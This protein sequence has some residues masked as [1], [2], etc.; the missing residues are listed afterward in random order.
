MSDG[1]A[2]LGWCLRRRGRTLAVAAALGGAAQVLLVA[3]PWAVQRALDRGVTPGATAP[4]LAWSGA[5]VGLG[6]AVVAARTVGQR[7][8]YLA[9]AEVVRA[10]RER[11]TARVLELDRAGLAGL[12]PGDAASRH[13]RDADQLW[14]WIGG[15]VDTVQLLVATAATVVAIALLDPLLALAGLAAVPPMLLLAR[16]F[17][18]RYEAASGRL[19][20][21]HAERT[22][23]VEALV[24][25]A[26]TVRGTGGEAELLARHAERSARV[27]AATRA[28]A[29]VAAPWSALVGLVPLLAAVAGLVIGGHALV[30]G[31]LT[32]GGLVAFAA[33]TTMLA[34]QVDELVAQQAVR[35]A[36]VASADRLA[37]VLGR[38]PRPAGSV[39][40]PGRGRLRA[41]GVVVRH[42]E[43]EVVRLPR[44]EIGPGE[45]V[46]LRGTTGSGK[47][48]LL[49]VLAGL[50]RPAAGTVSF[51]GVDLAAADPETVCARIGYVPQRPVLV[52]GTVAEN[53]LL[54]ASEPDDRV[55]AAVALD[56]LPAPGTRVGAGA[57]GLSGGQ[58]QRLAVARALLA[59]PAVLLLDDVTSSVDPGTER[60]VLDGLRAVRPD[61]AVVWASH[62]AAVHEAADRVVELRGGS[63]DAPGEPVGGGRG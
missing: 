39:P 9:G 60:R 31:T 30:A 17:P 35:R 59:R 32:V 4:L 23:V 50:D 22:A 44:F 6:A 1:R 43:R 56:D 61:L 63:L 15:V 47:S 19:A 20:E 16:V 42:D 27:S 34:A 51:G 18:G 2:L 36:A 45:L 38:A 7:L 58:T 11:L 41:E 57:A 13:G 52:P 10:V 3:V 53:L 48:E 8:H 55:S 24:T 12:S 40:L 49:R 5:V 33:W 54:G 21:A 28:A 25:G 14:T 62:R 26:D 29:R 46:V 37:G